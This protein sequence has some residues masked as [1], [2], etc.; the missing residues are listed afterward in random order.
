MPRLA[1][2]LAAA[3][4]L[5]APARADTPDQRL[6]SRAL[7]TAAG[8]YCLHFAYS[9]QDLR[10]SL[11]ESGMPQLPPEAAATLLGGRPGMAYNGSWNGVRVVVLSA[12]DGTCTVQAGPVVE[13]WVW[14]AVENNLRQGARDFRLWGDRTEPGEVPFRHR[15]Y[16]WVFEARRY[17]VLVSTPQG[18]T[19]LPASIAV[20]PLR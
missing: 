3:L 12:D 20:A 4:T 11:A 5:A 9:Q 8:R 13:R 7:V 1:L 6:G 18:N 19:P 2:F 15:R 16:R 10:A 17:Q 14:S